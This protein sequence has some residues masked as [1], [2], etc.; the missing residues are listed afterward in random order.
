MAR[1]LV[2]LTWGFS[3]PRTAKTATGLLRLL[4][5]RMRRSF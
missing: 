2:L 3:N 4:P 5:R 1:K